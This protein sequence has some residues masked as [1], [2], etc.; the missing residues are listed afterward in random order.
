VAAEPSREMLTTR[1][2][3]HAVT[4]TRLHRAGGGRTTTDGTLDV[5]SITGFARG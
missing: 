2:C 3:S 1:Q 5:T 4:R